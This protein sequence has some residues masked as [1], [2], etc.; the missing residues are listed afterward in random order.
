MRLKHLA[1]S[2]F[3]T[4]T[5]LMP[6]PP[7]L[8]LS[9]AATT[10]Q[11]N[12]P[13]VATGQWRKTDG[14]LFS[15]VRANAPHNWAYFKSIRPRLKYLKKAFQI[16][17]IAIGDFHILNIGDIE[18]HDGHRKIGLIDV[19]DGGVASLFADFT[20]AAISNQVSPYKVPLKTLWKA[21]LTGLQDQKTEKPELIRETLDRSHDDFIELNKSY[22]QKLIDGKGF[23][24]TAAVRPIEEADPLTMDI[25]LQSVGAF[26]QA[27]AGTEILAQGFKVKATG[28]SQGVPRFWFLVKHND[29]KFVVEFKTLAEPAMELYH[30]QPPQKQRI[31]ALIEAY[32]PQ[33]TT[34]GL[35]RFVDG[36]KYQFIARQRLKSFIALDPEGTS[37]QKEIIQGQGIYQYMANRAGTWHVEQGEGATLYAALTENEESAFQEFQAIV[38]NYIEI[39]KAENS[40]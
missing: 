27:L 20:R 2:I 12:S 14:N 38:N 29:S 34:V 7:A 3:L 40:R 26:Q 33:K 25:Y 4:A 1:L 11:G 22:T 18:L 8:P 24:A 5:G 37:T 6:A 28:G 9:H 36:G 31:E 35:Y 19:D 13:L 30:S 10:G 16:E 17:G 39:M 32:R 23:S 15:A 21:Y